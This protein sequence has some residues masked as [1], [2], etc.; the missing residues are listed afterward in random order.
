MFDKVVMRTTWTKHWSPIKPKPQDG[1]EINLKLVCFSFWCLQKTLHLNQ[2]VRKKTLNICCSTNHWT[3]KGYSSYPRSTP[4]TQRHLTTT[5]DYT[6]LY[7][8]TTKIYACNRTFLHTFFRSKVSTSA[9]TDGLLNFQFYDTNLSFFS[10]TA[11]LRL[12]SR[13]HIFLSRAIHPSYPN[14]NLK[15]YKGPS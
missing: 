3:L 14:Y 11:F 8:F 10:R 15:H 4:L 12:W 13:S 6:F 2:F 5:T 9:S 7:N 1:H